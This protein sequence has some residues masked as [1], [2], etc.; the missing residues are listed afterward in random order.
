MLFVIPAQASSFPRRRESGISMPQEFI[1]KNQNPPVIPAQAGIWNFNASRIY[2]KKPKP[3]SFPRRRESSFFEFQLFLI[4]SC[5][6]EFLDSRFRGKDAERLL[7]VIPAQASSF[8]RR[9]E[10]RFVRFRF[11]PID[12]CPLGV[13]DSRFRGKDAERLL[14]VI[15]AQASSFPRRR[16]SGISMPQEFIGKNQN[17]PVIPAQAGI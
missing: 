12:S 8:P 17:P 3:P 1:G 2:R 13:L 10:S 9:R 16:E 15:P 5:S 7:F 4:N 11:F 14:F 6:F